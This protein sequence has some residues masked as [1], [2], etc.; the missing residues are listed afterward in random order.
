MGPANLAVFD[1]ASLIGTL[2]EGT[3]LDYYA[4]PGPN[5]FKAMAPGADT[6][7]YATSL[8]AGQTY[9]LM[10]YFYGDQT[11]GAAA[12]TPVDAVTATRQMVT[13]KSTAGSSNP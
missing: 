5:I 12:I 8:V 6:I 7:P 3:Y 11:R 13:L 2:P 1:S 4:D 10:V 9:Y